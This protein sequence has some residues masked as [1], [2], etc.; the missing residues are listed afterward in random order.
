MAD[1]SSSVRS[2]GTGTSGGNSETSSQRSDAKM[3]EKRKKYVGPGSQ[4]SMRGLGREPEV[5]GDQL[6]MGN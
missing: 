6:C 4:K 2:G 1:D 5:Q 3:L